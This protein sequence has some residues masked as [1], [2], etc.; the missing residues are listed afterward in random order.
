M[1]R[2]YRTVQTF[3]FMSLASVVSAQPAHQTPDSDILEIQ[4]TGTRNLYMLQDEI[5]VAQD[6]MYALF[7]DINEDDRYDFRCRMEAPTGTRLERKVCRPGFLDDIDRENGGAFMN[8]V[9]GSGFPTIPRSSRMI[10]SREIPVL[11]EKIMQ[12]II[13]SPELEAATRELN[14]LE[15]E[16]QQRVSMASG[17]D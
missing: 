4:V 10:L 6:R 7:N 5:A 2:A 11:E 1:T 12:A 8:L 16:Y 14:Q 3:L 9:Q 13:S 17:N 15:E